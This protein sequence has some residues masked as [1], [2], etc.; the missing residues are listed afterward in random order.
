MFRVKVEEQTQVGR[1]GLASHT[2]GWRRG[3]GQRQGRKEEEARDWSPRT[4][5]TVTQGL[6]EP[7][8]CC[9]IPPR[10]GPAALQ[11]LQQLNAP[12]LQGDARTGS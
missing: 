3:K 8:T 11:S 1:R 5:E 4:T 7:R 2:Q 6:R 10:P 9:A 12:D